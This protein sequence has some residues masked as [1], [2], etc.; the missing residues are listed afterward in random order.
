LKITA[1]L[2]KLYL[3]V[4]PAEMSFRGLMLHVPSGCLPPRLTVSTSLL[5]EVLS[6]EL[7]GREV[8]V[9]DI[10]CGVGALALL[11]ARLGHYAVGTE[12]KP[13]CAAAARVNARRNG[14]DAYIDVVVCD[15]ASCLRGGFG[16][17]V[18]NP[19]FLLVEGDPSYACGRG[20][21]V[22][23][24]I[25]LEAVDAADTVIYAWSSLSGPS[26]IGGVEVA[27]RRGL[28]DRVYVYRV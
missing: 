25:L 24:K 20:C 8:A 22:A 12:I 18:V 7:A 9:L 14:V 27:S 11:A 19:P 5:A 3:R 10:G 23:A 13:R 16:A 21:G 17:A 2:L 26:P 15:G 4:H 6:E 1:L 28:F